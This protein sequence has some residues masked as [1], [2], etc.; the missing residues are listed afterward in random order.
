[1]VPIMGCAARIPKPALWEAPASEVKPLTAM[2]LVASSPTY[3]EIIQ[4]LN[5][6]SCEKLVDWQMRRMEDLF[7]VAEWYNMRSKQDPSFVAIQVIKNQLAA[8]A[9]Y[10]DE[11]KN[12]PDLEELYSWL[13]P[14]HLREQVAAMKGVLV[15]GFHRLGRDCGEK[16]AN[17]WEAAVFGDAKALKQL[18]INDP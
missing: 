4:Q 12:N 8:K 14:R 6:F 16:N 3:R 17:L 7:K 2:Q 11:W 10:G 15:L 1:M 9:M 5:S 13:G 18:G